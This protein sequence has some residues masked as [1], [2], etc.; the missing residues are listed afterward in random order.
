MAA[1]ETINETIIETTQ[2][3]LQQ[4][5]S[6]ACGIYDIASSSK[7]GNPKKY[8]DKEQATIA[9]REQRKNARIRYK[10]NQKKLCFQRQ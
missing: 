4:I 1:I 9:A 5:E 3:E 6:A 10:Y 8:T 7:Q 2:T